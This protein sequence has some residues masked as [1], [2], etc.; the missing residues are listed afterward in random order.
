MKYKAIKFSRSNQAEFISDLRKRVKEYF[1]TNEISV[2]GNTTM[3]TKT[4]VMFLLYFAPYAFMLSGLITNTWV[5]LLMWAIMGIGM[6]GIGL[7][8]MHDAN[9]GAYS[10]NKHVN[11]YMGYVMNIIGASA[12]NWKVQHNVLHHSFTNIEGMDEDIDPGKLMRLS[13]HAPLLK[14][15][16]LQHI[17][18]WFLYGLMTFLWL[19]TKDFKQLYRYKKLGL[20][21]AQKRTYT[22]VL[23]ETIISKIVYYGYALVLPLI[24]IPAP[25]WVVLLGFFI[26]HF[27]T[28]L[29]LG[30]IF[31]PAHVMPTSEYPIPDDTGNLETNWAVHQLFTTT[32]FAPKSKLFSWY[33]GGLNF[34][35]E[36]HLFP[37]I[38]HVHY[39]KISKIVMETTKEYGLPYNSEKSFF[40]AVAAHAKML[41]SLGRNQLA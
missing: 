25:T 29:S 12:F 8:V 14:V 11:K 27:I 24:F 1:E 39:K 28:G 15:H 19:T 18:G 16:K 32:N 40:S 22:G 21:K 2:Y 17:Y 13:P 34:Q 9:H 30:L 33:V 31:Q 5:L 35:I 7:S 41:K 38:C 36:H 10:K 23:I 20:L 26:M 3:V 4:I 6:S 37:N